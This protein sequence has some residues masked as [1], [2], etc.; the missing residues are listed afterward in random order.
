MP[1]AP[2]PAA[3]SDA[4]TGIPGLDEVLLGGLQRNRVYVLEGM[5]GSGKTTLAL[6]FLLEGAR[7][8][9]PGL[10]FTLSETSDELNAVASSHGWSLAG[11]SVCELVPGEE[12][13]RPDA[14]VRMFHPSEVE[15]ADTTNTILAAVDRERPARVVLDSLSELRLLSQSSLRYRRQVLALKQF[16]AGRGCTV[17]LLDDL[18]SETRD[19]QL[20]SV[21][22]G[23][24]TLESLPLGYGLERR[25][26]RVVKYRGRAYRGGHHDFV[27]RRGGIEVFPRLVADEHPR[28]FTAGRVESGVP[29]LDALLGGGLDRGTSTLVLGSSGL[30]KSVFASQYVAAAAERGECSVMFM[31]DES[32][33][34]ALARA[35][36]IGQD[37]AAHVDAGRVLLREVDPGQLGPGEFAHAVKQAVDVDHAR[38]VALDSLNGYLQAMPDERFLTT[39]LHELLTF[40]GKAGVV[41]ILIVAQSGLVGPAVNAPIDATYLADTVVSLRFFEA[42]GRLRRAVSVV[43]KRRGS[44]EDTLRE[45]RIGADGI[46]L[47]EP[48]ENLQGVLTGTPSRVERD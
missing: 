13:L 6:H 42:A 15:L 31:F 18:T 43:K 34:T 23:V 12:D 39:H 9:E 25:R 47:G 41:T 46:W 32:A 8:G 3:D 5:P 14:Q 24:L 26:L 30:G 7:H 11:L 4:S 1:N 48:L 10:Y 44:H 17:L 22:H 21:A 35:A 27:L 45:F 2:R 36:G 38:V 40:L 20:H 29:E 19:L 37:L 28:E 33:G 16:F